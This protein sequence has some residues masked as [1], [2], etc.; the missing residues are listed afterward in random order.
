MVDLALEAPPLAKTVDIGAVL[1]AA[2]P[3]SASLR[4]LTLGP[5]EHGTSEPE[6]G[7]ECV[8]VEADA[9][10][11]LQALLELSETWGK[12]PL[13]SFALREFK[14]KDAPLLAR[15]VE[16][17]P[18][19]VVTLRLC[20]LSG[21]RDWLT[22]A[23]AASPALQ[24]L[25]LSNNGFGDQDVERLAAA[26]AARQ[27]DG[28][29]ALDLGGNPS[30]SAAGLR[31]L[32]EGCGPQLALLEELDVSECGLSQLGASLLAHS[33]G[34][35]PKLRCL[36]AH[37]SGLGVDG[38]L[39]LLSAGLQQPS[40]RSLNVAANGQ[41]SA[42]WLASVGKRVAAALASVPGHGLRTLTLSCPEKELE[43]AKA[44]LCAPEQSFRVILVPN[45]Q[46]NYNRRMFLG[47]E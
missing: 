33:M 18:P 47:A 45:E 31:L 25:D 30:L 38:M 44:L 8:E 29:L 4:T 11:A 2:T 1:E 39:Q 34:A 19:S 35:L 41:H 36:N 17:L 3:S 43:D 15:L 20:G 37:R 16:R 40:L 46:N 6:P 27:Q 13:K 24:R 23:L 32:L 10:A 7:E 14:V 26:L 42:L 12:W 28:L 21:S 9:E 5:W 22:P